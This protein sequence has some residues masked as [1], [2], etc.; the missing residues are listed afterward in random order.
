MF[1][2]LIYIHTSAHTHVIVPYLVLRKLGC[3]RDLLFCPP[4]T[5]RRGRNR[6]RQLLQ[7]YPQQF[8]PTD[9]PDCL[10]TPVA[11]PGSWPIPETP[12]CLPF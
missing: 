10:K 11:V 9:G 1:Y 3:E 6:P 4:S 2:I 5:V 8:A 7:V 12:S